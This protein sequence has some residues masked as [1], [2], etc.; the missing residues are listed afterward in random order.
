M[1]KLEATGFEIIPNPYKRKLTQ[2]ELKEL[3]TDVKG[4]IAGLEPLNKE[5]LTASSLE[6]ISRCGSG[7]SNVDLDTVEKMNIQF[8]STPFGP[9]VSVAE[10]TLCNIIA[11]LRNLP[12]VNKQMHDGIWEKNTGH[13]LSGKMVVIIG[14]GKIGQAVA[15]LLGAFKVNIL[16][17]DPY[18]KEIGYKGSAI[19]SE[20]NDA[21][22]KADIILIHS[23]GEE[24]ILTRKEFG[25]IKKGAFLLNAS[26]GPLV[27]EI[28]LIEALD[29]KTISGAWLDV[30]SHEPYS[31][32]LCE[33]DNVILTPHISSYTAEGR[34]NMEN[35]AVDNLIE[36]FRIK[37]L[38]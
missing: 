8:F 18:L 6:V 38:I 9:T 31:G 7:I 21:L 24:P 33:Y 27:D 26:R 3:L 34:L 17:V 36:G 14:F 37:G 16:A 30:F 29:D 4:I 10:L 35:D 22:P 1:E 32:P 12:A 23:S 20:I 5:V 11:L 15:N 13:L 2:D 19:V 28:A 25:I